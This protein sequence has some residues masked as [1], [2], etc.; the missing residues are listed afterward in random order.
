MR[1]PAEADRSER[2]ELHPL[3]G[4]GG[5]RV[6]AIP[7]VTDWSPRFHL[8]VLH[9]GSNR[10][11]SIECRGDGATWALL[12]RGQP[13]DAMHARAIVAILLP[14]TTLLFQGCDRGTIP[15]EGSTRRV[16]MSIAVAT[17]LPDH[18]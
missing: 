18:H 11:R 6:H 2:A 7:P 17:Q 9:Y 3:R 13:G 4:E 14:L 5:A 10:P 16:A 1:D 12:E 15:T 8:G